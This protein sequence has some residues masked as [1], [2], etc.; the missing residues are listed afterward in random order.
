MSTSTV[1]SGYGGALP[2][3]P[4]QLIDSDEPDTGQGDGASSARCSVSLRCA[5]VIQD[6]AHAAGQFI[7]AFGFLNSDVHQGQRLPVDARRW[8]PW[9]N[10]THPP[11]RCEV[12]STICP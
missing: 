6:R 9:P 1:S 3:G 10:A 12:T 2:G 7:G 11:A 4:R 5:L 8:V